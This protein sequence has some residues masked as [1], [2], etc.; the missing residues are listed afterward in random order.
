MALFLIGHGL[1]DIRQ[2]NGPGFQCF[3]GR[4]PFGPVPHAGQA[5]L[6]DIL[7]LCG[8]GIAMGVGIDLVGWL[9]GHGFCTCGSGTARTP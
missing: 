5:I 6:W 9:I 7:A 8:A 3:L 2:I 4:Q 1:A